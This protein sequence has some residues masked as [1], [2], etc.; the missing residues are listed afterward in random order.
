MG[1]NVSGDGSGNLLSGLLGGLLGGNGEGGILSVVTG[2]LGGLIN[3]VLGVFLWT[4]GRFRQQDNRI[5]IWMVYKCNTK[6]FD[7][8]QSTND[9]DYYFIPLEVGV[10]ART[11]F[12]FD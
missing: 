9:F 3:G 5:A 1:A 11:L 8:L 10:N 12:L 2:L 4:V 7:E 6:C